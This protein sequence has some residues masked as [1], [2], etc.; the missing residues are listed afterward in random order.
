MHWYSAS[1][2]ESHVCKHTQDDLPILPNDLAFAH[3]PLEAVLSTS[4]STSDPLPANIILERAKAAKQYL[5]EEASK[6]T[7]SKHPTK[8]V[9]V[10]LSKKQKDK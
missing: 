7:P 5:E 6:S 8:Q 10:K 4:G 1:T 9:P 2:W 3:M